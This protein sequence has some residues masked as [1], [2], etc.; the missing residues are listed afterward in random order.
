MQDILVK[1]NGDAS[2]FEKATNK[3][4]GLSKSFA[5]AIGI[6]L[7]TAGILALSKSLIDISDKYSQLDGRLRLVTKS[8]NEL[9]QHERDC[10]RSRRTPELNTRR[11][12]IFTPGLLGQRI[13]S[14]YRNLSFFPLPTPS[15]KL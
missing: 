12:L 14:G 5:G 3:A 9:T 15:I 4:I 7:G 8:S 10:M 6:S 13:S 2:G 11:P 1:I